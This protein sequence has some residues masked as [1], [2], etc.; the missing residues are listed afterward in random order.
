M[1]AAIQ[2]STA[3]VRPARRPKHIQRA[4]AAADGPKSHPCYAV[5]WPVRQDPASQVVVGGKSDTNL[6]TATYLDLSHDLT[7]T[8]GSF[9]QRI[10][11]LVLRPA[12]PVCGRP[13]AWLHRWLQA[14]GRW[15][16]ASGS[17]VCYLRAIV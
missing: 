10:L 4:Q 3:R 17:R 5:R 1:P 12:A 7:T 14:S 6:P 8:E 2:P 11:V 9:H 13:P 16:L 15:P